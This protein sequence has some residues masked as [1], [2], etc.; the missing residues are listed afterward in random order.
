MPKGVEH[1]QHPGPIAKI[2]NCVESLMPKGV[3]HNNPLTRYDN[4]PERVES[5]M[6]KGV[7][8][9]LIYKVRLFAAKVLNL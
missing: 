6:P 5:L 4:L 7:E 1:Y 9:N 8:H 2:N 3:E